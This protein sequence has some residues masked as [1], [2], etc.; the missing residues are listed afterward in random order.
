[1]IN[2]AYSIA[3]AVL[4]LS[5][6]LSLVLALSLPLTACTR[7]YSLGAVDAAGDGAAGDGAAGDGAA[8]DGAAGD[9]ANA[10]ASTDAVEASQD[11]PLDLRGDAPGDGPLDLPGD[12]PG[13][14]PRDLPGDAPGDAPLAVCLDNGISYQLGAI[15]PRGSSACPNSCVC[16]AGGVIGRCTGVCPADASGDP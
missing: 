10:D 2:L 11:G 13:D 4:S 16:L 7:V 14:A 12:A 9:G 6:S 3:R 5:S 8:G 15:I 1:M